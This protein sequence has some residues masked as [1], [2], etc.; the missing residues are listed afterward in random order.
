M[1]S[2]LPDSEI[3]HKRF[4]ENIFTSPIVALNPNGQP[5]ITPRMPFFRVAT[6]LWIL[7]FSAEAADNSPAI[8][9][10]THCIAVD[11][12]SARLL[13][14]K[15]ALGKPVYVSWEAYQKEYHAI[16]TNSAGTD[17]LSAPLVV[18]LDGSF[19]MDICDAPC[20]S[21]NRPVES[22]PLLTNNT[23]IFWRFQVAA[24]TNPI[25]MGCQFAY[26]SREEISIVRKAQFDGPLSFQ[27]NQVAII[28]LPQ[29]M[30]THV[31]QRT[32]FGIPAGKKRNVLN[33]YFVITLH[34]QTQID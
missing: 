6:L 16:W 10:H 17:Y 33:R 4:F 34:L 24:N 20:G 8:T 3:F 23:G 18:H 19:G 28:R 32:I 11:R 1:P 15:L 31:E 22:F 2:K 13:E 30:E 7:C 21:T 27:S 25:T 14:K 29:V 5:T 9:I 26:N 12:D